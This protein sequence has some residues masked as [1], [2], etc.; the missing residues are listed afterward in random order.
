MG[1]LGHKNVVGFVAEY[2]LKVKIKDSELM[3]TLRQM[4]NLTHARNFG[5]SGASN[6]EEPKR[7]EKVSGFDT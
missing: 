3:S 1:S 4:R 7:G 5:C 6:Y 2:D